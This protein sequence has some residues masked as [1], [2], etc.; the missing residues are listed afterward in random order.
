MTKSVKNIF[1]HNNETALFTAK[2]AV[3]NLPQAVSNFKILSTWLHSKS[4]Q[5]PAEIYSTIIHHYIT[6]LTVADW[7]C[8]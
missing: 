7:Y 5:K 3:I 8:L 2:F 4:S 1:T 6:Y